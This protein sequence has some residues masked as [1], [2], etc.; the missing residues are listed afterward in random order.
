MQIGINT[1][2]LLHTDLSHIQHAR[3]LAGSFAEALALFGHQVWWTF[4]LGRV[5][6]ELQSDLALAI[7]K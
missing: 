1:L 2:D 5:T 7:G 3:S 6:I 4:L